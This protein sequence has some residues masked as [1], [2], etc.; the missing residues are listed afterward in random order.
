MPVIGLAVVLAV[1]RN[2]E[3]DGGAVCVIDGSPAG[4]PRH[5]QEP[6]LELGAAVPSPI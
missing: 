3:P 5:V 1:R 4:R 6:K 2:D